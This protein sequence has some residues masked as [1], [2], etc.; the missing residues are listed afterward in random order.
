MRGSSQQRWRSVPSLFLATARS[1]RPPRFQRTRSVPTAFGNTGRVAAACPLLERYGYCGE[2]RGNK[3]TS[4]FLRAFRYP[5]QFVQ[6]L[7]RQLRRN[8]FVADRINHDIIE[9]GNSI[10]IEGLFWEELLDRALGQGFR[11][12]C[13]LRIGLGSIWRRINPIARFQKSAH[14]P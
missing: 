4:L 9:P 6:L 11:Q 5:Y 10:G 12:V 1:Q 3:E 8:I 2:P 13:P 14:E 7:V